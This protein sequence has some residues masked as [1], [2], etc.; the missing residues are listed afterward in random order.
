MKKFILFDFDGTITDTGEGIINAVEYTL[1]KM[2][3]DPGSEADRRRFVGPPLR[4][5]FERFSDM[6][7]PTAT[8]AVRVYREYYRETGLFEASLYDGVTEQLRRL[9]E[10]GA[11]T[12]VASSKPTIFINKLIEHFGITDLF[13]FVAGSE[14]DGTHTDK[15]EVIA[16]AMEHLGAAKEDTVMVGDRSHDII[17]AKKHGLASVGVLYGYGSREELTESGADAIAA[18]T[19]ELYD[20]IANIR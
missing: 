11:V 5:A 15:A 8:E 19:T 13:D 10:S 18:E 9:R 7:T 17:G 14:L 4:Q 12:A 1:V 6:D 2:G 20:I 16:I 3:K